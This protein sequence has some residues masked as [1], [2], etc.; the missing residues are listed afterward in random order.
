MPDALTNVCFWGKSG[1]GQN[2]PQ[3]PFMTQLFLLDAGGLDDLGPLLGF[4]GDE[5]AGKLRI[6]A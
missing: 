5:M 2:A 3:C 1:H 4:R 6:Y